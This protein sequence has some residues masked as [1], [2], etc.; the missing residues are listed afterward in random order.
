[1]A[2]RIALCLTTG[3]ACLAGAAAALAD[4]FLAQ[5]TEGQPAPPAGASACQ[6]GYPTLG[7]YDVHSTVRLRLPGAALDSVTAEVPA[8]ADGIFFNQSD[9]FGAPSAHGKF[10]QMDMHDPV[11]DSHEYYICL[12]EGPAKLFC[13]PS[14]S[15]G[16]LS[17]YEV[18]VCPETCIVTGLR[19]YALA[20]AGVY[21]D[22][23]TPLVGTGQYDWQ[24]GAVPALDKV[25]R[26]AGCE[27][28]GAAASVAPCGGGYPPMDGEAINL[29]AFELSQIGDSAPPALGSR[30]LSVSFFNQTDAESGAANATG[31]FVQAF[32]PEIGFYFLCVFSEGAADLTCVD[33][34]RGSFFM[35]MTVIMDDTCKPLGLSSVISYGYY[36]SAA[37]G[38]TVTVS[39]VAL[40]VE[41]DDTGDMPSTLPM[42]L[43]PV[44]GHQY[45]IGMHVL[46][47]L[48]NGTDQVFFQSG[49]GEVSF[50]AVA[51]DGQDGS[52]AFAQLTAGGQ[53]CLCTAAA[54]GESLCVQTGDSPLI[55]DYR[56]DANA[57]DL[58]MAWGWGVSVVAQMALLSFGQ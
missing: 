23:R 52:E 56:F 7:T 10:V 6:G 37:D 15:A 31:Q 46:T 9:D 19:Q 24:W 16:R 14:D 28:V 13:T 38:D 4:G 20:G 21:G 32:S 2:S 22:E 44:L 1:M 57:T 33:T 3:A 30:H 8:P 51:G 42:S 25:L 18:A 47:A 39:S 27:V 36:E 5:R 40:A 48:G 54:V 12:F 50:A 41:S 17:R 34:V 53:T 11:T 58:E 29:T 55:V 35:Q 49:S 45:S 26:A 43:A